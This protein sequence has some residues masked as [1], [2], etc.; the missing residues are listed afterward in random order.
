MT[1]LALALSFQKQVEGIERVSVSNSHTAVAGLNLTASKPSKGI[2]FM[3][4]VSSEI[5]SP[6]KGMK[7]FR[8]RKANFPIRSDISQ[9]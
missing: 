8:I 3:A 7:F 1:I 5:A 9:Y 2:S 4:R 6:R